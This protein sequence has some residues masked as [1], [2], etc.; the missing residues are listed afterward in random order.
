MAT[1]AACVISV[2]GALKAS[3]G[4]QINGLEIRPL[5]GCSRSVSPPPPE[6]WCARAAQV[7][8]RAH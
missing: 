7:E 1:L 3:E 5:L 4:E 8:M 6:L 2:G